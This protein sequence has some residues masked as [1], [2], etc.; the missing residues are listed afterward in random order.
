MRRYWRPETRVDLVGPIP[1]AQYVRMSD[2]MQQY[3]IDNQKT[4]IGEYAASHGFL[5][6]KTYSDPGKSGVLAKNRKGLSELLK[7]V[8]SGTAQFKA[9]LVFD[10]SRWGRFQDNDEAAYYEFLCAKS[11]I[12]LHYCAE[13]FNNDGTAISSLLKALKR[14]MAAEFSREL[15]EKVLR[16]KTRIIQL[17]FRVGGYP[18]YGFRRVMVS[19]NGTR[20]Q[21]MNTGEHKSFTTD[22]VILVPGP[23]K[24][25]EGIKEMFAM[26]TERKGC[27][28]I[29]RQLNLRGFVKQGRPW[30]NQTVY[31][32]ITNPNYVGHNVWGRTTGRLRTTRITLPPDRWVK[33]CGAFESLVDQETF[34]RAQTR[35]L[36]IAD[37]RWTDEQILK[38]ARQLIKAKGRISEKLILEAQNMPASSTIHKHFG[39]YRQFYKKLG[40]HLEEQ[41]FYRGEE[42][43][44]SLQLRRALVSKI[45]GLFPE[46]VEITH[47][48]QHT[49]SILRIDNTFL[50]S[51]L[52]CRTRGSG[53]GL[54]WV[55]EPNPLERNYVTLFCKMNT[56]HDHVLSYNLFAEMNFKSHRSCVNDPWLKNSLRLRKLAD[57]YVSVKKL[58]SQ[59]T[60]TQAA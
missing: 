26:A 7:D 38:R 31:Y 43:E 47:A 15:G 19:A 23:T 41:D 36:K 37:Y 4:A 16:G 39:S 58:W 54:C 59:K 11:G 13:P 10:V 22:R 52:L 40:Y 18:G 14:S 34:D 45:K 20:K 48:P 5:V 56:T 8:V 30:T 50:V 46:H 32:T 42:C 2:D 17:G 29:A 49:R 3:S 12:P 60:G 57:F 21:E 28:E 33:K 44:R 1:A 25:V 35:L 53:R 51:V 27:A 9:I 55:V 24:E 6:I